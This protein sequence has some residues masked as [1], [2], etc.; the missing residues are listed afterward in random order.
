M[1]WKMFSPQ[2]IFQ[3]AY[4]L[5]QYSTYPN[6]IYRFRHLILSVLTMWS[7]PQLWA[8]AVL[9]L[10]I[11]S[12][13]PSTFFML[14]FFISISSGYTENRHEIKAMCIRYKQSSR[15]RKFHEKPKEL[16]QTGCNCMEEFQQDLFRKSWSARDKETVIWAQHLRLTIIWM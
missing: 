11:C 1:V 13:K 3:R 16:R 14:Y 5:K 7:V 8:L 15:E 9:L 10:N 2:N 6:K 4:Q 12:G